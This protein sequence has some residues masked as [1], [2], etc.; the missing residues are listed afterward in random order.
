[1]KLSET[2][3][4]MVELATAIRDYWS[5]ELPKRHLHYP[6]VSPGEDSGPSPPEEAE[7]RDF[8]AGLSE[9]KIYKLLLLLYL[10]RG[11]FHATT[12]GRIIGH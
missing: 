10:G 8:L 11:E 4:R 12:S 7:L 6:I 1:M 3:A 9:E 5:T 2:A